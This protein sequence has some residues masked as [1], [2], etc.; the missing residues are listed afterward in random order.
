MSSSS[1]AHTEGVLRKTIFDVGTQTLERCYGFSRLVDVRQK[2]SKERA[3]V[4]REWIL[5]LE[6]SCVLEFR[7]KCT[8][9]IQT[10]SSSS[11]STVQRSR[12]RQ[13]DEN[14]KRESGDNGNRRGR[15]LL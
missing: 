2:S 5:G 12:E 1:G 15:L 8:G 14:D 11:D 7:L 10:L 6:S 4:E 9:L 3:C 13:A